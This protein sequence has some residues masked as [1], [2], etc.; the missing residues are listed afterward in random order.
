M[1]CQHLTHAY[2]SKRENVLYW[3]EKGSCLKVIDSVSFSDIM[4]PPE[5]QMLNLENKGCVMGWSLSLHTSTDS[6]DRVKIQ[7]VCESKDYNHLVHLRRKYII[8]KTLHK[9]DWIREESS[10][11]KRHFNCYIHVTHRLAF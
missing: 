9:T 10:K 1:L 6:S 4:L 2:Q 3:L 8:S 11:N 5:E 7:T